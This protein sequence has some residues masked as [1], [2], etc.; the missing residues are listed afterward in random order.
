VPAVAGYLI[1]R[2]AIKNLA[3]RSD[4]V[5]AA[6]VGAALTGGLLAAAA[7][8]ARGGVGDGRWSTFGAPPVLLGAVVAVEVG[9]IAI[10]VAALAGGRSVPSR[11]GSPVRTD[12]AM[13]SRIEPAADVAADDGPAED[14]V[15]VEVEVETIAKTEDDVETEDDIGTMDA[16]ESVDVARSD[17]PTRHTET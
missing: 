9:A 8:I 16:A 4:R 12:E 13:K 6:A 3:T 10:A 15:K 2:S 1:A 5:L 7:A 14:E 11:S 17:D